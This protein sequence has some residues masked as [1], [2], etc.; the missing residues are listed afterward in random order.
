MQERQLKT[1]AKAYFKL[2][3]TANWIDQQVKSCLHQF[4][5]THPQYNVLRILRGSIPMPLSSTDI[6]DRMIVISP[7]MT[8][9]LDRLIKKELIDKRICPDNRRKVEVIISEK[10]IELLEDIQPIIMEKVQYFYHDQISELEAQQL[11][12]ILQ[13]IR[14]SKRE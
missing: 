11:Y 8:R 6:K 5:I 7:D 1:H 4:D 3:E 9:L 14:I 2:L 10:G 12:D 13:K